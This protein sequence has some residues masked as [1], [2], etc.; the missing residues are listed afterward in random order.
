MAPASVIQD[1]GREIKDPI[2]RGSWQYYNST[3]ILLYYNIS[4]N[5]INN[6]INNKLNFSNQ[7]P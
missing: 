1:G 6:V 4:I 2:E 7:C 5:L 3:I